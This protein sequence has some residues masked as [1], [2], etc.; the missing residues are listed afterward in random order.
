MLRFLRAS[1][2]CSLALVLGFCTAR[3]LRSAFADPL[4]ASPLAV[5]A[6][7]LNRA[8]HPAPSNLSPIPSA[9]PKMSCA[10]R[11]V[12]LA[13]D[14]KIV[15]KMSDLPEGVRKFYWAKGAPGAGMVD[16]GERFE[17]TDVITDPSLPSR[18]LIF[19]GVTQDRAF[20]HY[21]QGGIATFFVIEFFRLKSPATATSVW[22]G[23]D[24]PANGIEDL[25][26]LVSQGGCK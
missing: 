11:K 22:K 14:F 8:P 4:P 26:R 3:Y 1:L 25:R 13:G 12:F 9:E 5:P 7:D 19:A 24:G 17:S 18:R 15:R 21:E 23:F 20:I 10:E 6:L 16:P 2:L